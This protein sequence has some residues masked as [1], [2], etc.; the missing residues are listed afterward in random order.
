MFALEKNGGDSTYI[1]L[2]NSFPKGLVAKKGRKNKK[3]FWQK[4]VGIMSHPSPSI[5]YFPIYFDSF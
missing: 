4:I 1:F 3:A 2:Q 5:I